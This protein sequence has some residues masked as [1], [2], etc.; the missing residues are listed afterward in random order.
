MKIAA[1]LPMQSAVD[2]RWRE[3][4]PGIA[5]AAV[6]AFA[7]GAVAGGLGDPLARNPLLIAILIGLATATLGCPD[8]LSRPRFTSA[9]CCDWRR[10]WWIEHQDAL[11][12]TRRSA[13]RI[14]SFNVVTSAVSCGSRQSLIWTTNVADA[15]GVPWCGASANLAVASS[16]A[17][18]RRPQSRHTDT[19]FVTY[20]AESWAFLAVTARFD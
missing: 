15:A 3:R 17:L 14:P 1:T 16:R 2:L 13:A 6:L 4:L 10:G 5:V 19:V 7:A 20:R 9:I 12:P 18:G 11:L 8:Q